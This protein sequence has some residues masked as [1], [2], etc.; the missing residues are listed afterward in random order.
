MVNMIR[1]RFYFKNKQT[2]SFDRPWYSYYLSWLGIVVGVTVASCILLKL[3]PYGLLQLVFKGGFVATLIMVI[4]ALIW[5]FWDLDKCKGILNVWTI[6]NFKERFMQNYVNNRAVNRMNNLSW[7]VAPV[8]K[9]WFQDSNLIIKV[10]K[11]SG[12]YE[13]D[14]DKLVEDI[15]ANLSGR[16]GNYAV[17]SQLVEDTG[18]DFILTA[19]DVGSDLTFKPK[20]I[21]DLKQLPY[22]LK[23]QKNLVVALGHLACWGATGSGK[24][25]TIYLILAELFSMGADVYLIDP[26]LEFSKFSD[27]YGGF[28]PSEKFASDTVVV[29]LLL[30]NVCNKIKQRQQRIL[31]ASANATTSNGLTAKDLNL[32]PI[33]VVADEVSAVVASMSS[34]EKKQFLAYIT[35]I[36]QKG[37]SLGIYFVSASQDPSVQ[38]L[39]APIRS[40]FMTKILLASATGDVQREVFGT[41]ATTGNVPNFKGYYTSQ[42]LTVQPMRF[43]V[44][45]LIAYHLDN[46]DTFK[47]LY[48]YGKKI[49]Y[50]R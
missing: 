34:K 10:P 46:N 19:I 5:F 48:N 17:T 13:N 8:L 50:V 36:V 45:N 30:K 11:L 15:N 4:V 20:S 38:T 31:K 29:L 33:V 47:F 39:S 41:V 21:E 44:P 3:F 24:S 32:R 12:M 35:Q 2:G 26:K 49:N 43:F 28:Y 37:R 18:N 27:A 6:W 7:T 16:L 9:V 42:G 40:Q 22:Q 23:L 25:T 1:E 14:L